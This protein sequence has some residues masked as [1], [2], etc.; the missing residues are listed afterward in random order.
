MSASLRVAFAVSVLAI[1]LFRTES[2]AADVFSP[3][4]LADRSEPNAHPNSILVFAGRM[5]TTDIYS[6]MLFNLNKSDPG[7]V[8]DNYIVGAASDRDL[9][10]LGHGFFFGYEVGVDDRFGHY[11]VCC[12]TIVKSSS[13]VQSLELWAGSQIRYDGFLLFDRLRVGGAVT[14]GLSA[15]GDSIGRERQREINRAASARLLLY[16]GPELDFSTPSFPN[17]EFVL[18]LQHRSGANGTLGHMMEGYNANV[19]GLRCRF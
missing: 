4:P 13:I 9:F 14:G 5:S 10:N 12:D 2:H 19:A 6:T 1:F 18:K 11:Q 17:L 16:L 7:L 15:A 8:Y 3:V